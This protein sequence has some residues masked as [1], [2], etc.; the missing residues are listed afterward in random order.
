MQTIGMDHP[1]LIQ[2]GTSSYTKRKN[3]TT[4]TINVDYVMSE[5]EYKIRVNEIKKISDID[6]ELI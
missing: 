5:E 1:E 2:Y 6:W 4:V 3:D